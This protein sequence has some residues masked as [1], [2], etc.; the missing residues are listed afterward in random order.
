M[1]L[2]TK[3]RFQIRSL[4][5]YKDRQSYPKSDSLISLTANAII[6]LVL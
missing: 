5:L 6:Q 4:L 3:L 2:N 1:Y